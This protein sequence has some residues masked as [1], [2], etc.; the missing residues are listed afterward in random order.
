MLLVLIAFN[1]N[2]KECCQ[3]ADSAKR[4]LPCKFRQ[5]VADSARRIPPDG[6]G[7]LQANSARRWRISFGGIR[8]TDS[9]L[10]TF[11]YCY[12]FFCSFGFLISD[13]F[14]RA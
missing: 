9:A 10:F 4:I 8:Q 1:S 5:T 2:P 11:N 3:A 14:V 7:F 6:G 13:E 12:F